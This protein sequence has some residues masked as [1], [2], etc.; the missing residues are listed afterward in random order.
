MRASRVLSMRPTT[1]RL[2]G[3]LQIPYRTDATQKSTGLT[4][5]YEFPN[6]RPRLLRLYYETDRL[7][8]EFPE[9]SVYRKS[10]EGINKHRAAIVEANTE[11]FDIEQKIGGGLIEEIL[12]QAGEEYILAQKLLQWKAWE[13]LE[14]EPPVGVWE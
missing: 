3:R 12:I 10:V 14:D 11:V 4:G 1:V 8:Q 2:A 7:L 13:K 6:P 9:S 5:I